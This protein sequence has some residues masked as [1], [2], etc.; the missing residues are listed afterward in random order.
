[1]QET[2]INK[3]RLYEVLATA[4]EC[5]TA[6]TA[7]ALC[8]GEYIE[9]LSLFASQDA[10]LFDFKGDIYPYLAPYLTETEEVL[11]HRLRTEYTR[12]FVGAPK[13]LVSPYAGI[14]YADDKGLDALLFVNKESMAVERFMRQCGITRPENTNEPLDHISSELEFLNFLCLDKAGVLELPSSV[15]IDNSSYANFYS[16]HF[17]VWS[18]RFSAA[19]CEESTET[20]FTVFAK[21]TKALPEEPW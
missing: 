10:S 5:T 16:S 7:R 8:Q 17:S 1:M 20:F 19:V 18:K 21:I 2:W 11:L 3:A 4:F 14:W 13:A 9:Q 6:E 15:S 12:L